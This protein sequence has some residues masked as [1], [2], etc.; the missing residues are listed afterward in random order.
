MTAAHAITTDALSPRRA[1]GRL[2]WLLM[3]PLLAWLVVFVVAPTAILMAY[4]FYQPGGV[5]QAQFRW[6]D[7]AGNLVLHHNYRR[8]FDPAY[9]KVFLRATGEAAI[10]GA[11]AGGLVLAYRT[12]VRASHRWDDALVRFLVALGLPLGLAIV[13]VMV[14]LLSH[15]AGP[16]AGWQ[17]TWAAVR[18]GAWAGVVV[19]A[20]HVF[21]AR[22]RWGS[23][24]VLG[25]LAGFVFGFDAYIELVST[26]NYL[27]ILWRSVKYAAYT[28]VWCIVLGYPVAYFIG[29]ASEANRNRLLMLVMVPFWTSFLIRTFAWITILKR[30]GTLNGVLDVAGLSRL[31]A[32]LGQYPF[33]AEWLSYRGSPYITNDGDLDLLYTPAAI[34]IGLV[35]SYLPFMILPIYGSVEKLDNALVEAAFDLGAGPVRAF[36]HVIIPLT[37]PGIVAGCLLVFI[38][39]IGM[40]AIQDLLGGGR[41]PMIG[42]VIQNQF[43]QARNAPF[44]AALG[45]TL[46]LIF[47][48]AFWLTSKRRET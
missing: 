44:G 11:L 41:V 10:G 40:F 34:T 5:G 27:Q 17:A 28:T 21:F 35:Y 13:E 38:P 46:V 18:P 31:L 12:A 3:L 42:D 26:G 37:Q 14:A 16:S 8:I 2:G 9:L 48:V 32:R 22:D 39:A 7:D 25:L 4:S 36:Q 45:M 19:A 24:L 6:R 20:C 43:N 33:I 1:P 23:A 47:V 30:E 29:R 15:Q